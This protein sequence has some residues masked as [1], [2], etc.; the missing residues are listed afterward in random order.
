[1][2][3]PMTRADVY[4]IVSEDRANATTPN[5]RGHSVTTYPCCECCERGAVVKDKH[6]E[7]CQICQT[8]RDKMAQAWDDGAS[9]ARRHPFMSSEYIRSANPYRTEETR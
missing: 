6:L 4:R 5:L 3:A 1:M 9:F 2:T 7:P 8:D